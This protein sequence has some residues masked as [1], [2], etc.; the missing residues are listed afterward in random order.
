MNELPE[1]RFY[2][3]TVQDADILYQL[4]EERKPEESI[5]HKKMPTKQEHWKYVANAPYLRWYMIENEQGYVVGACYLTRED[6]F[7]QHYVGISIFKSARRRGY[8]T[9]ALTKLLEECKAL[10]ITPVANINP[11]NAKSIKLFESLGFK[12]I[13]LTYKPDAPA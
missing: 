4:L 10:F 6:A 12:L 5:S 7:G 2:E 3:A 13:Q 11:K 8:A 1:V 9:A